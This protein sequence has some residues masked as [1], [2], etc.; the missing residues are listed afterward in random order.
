MSSNETTLLFILGT[1][2]VLVGSFT[3]IIASKK[4]KDILASIFLAVGIAGLLPLLFWFVWTA[5]DAASV[6]GYAF[7]D[8]L[9]AGVGAFVVLAFS[10]PFIAGIP[11]ALS[12]W[13]SYVLFLKCCKNPRA[14]QGVDPND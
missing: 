6:H 8:A 14:E 1:F 4:Q 13:V 7:T 12:A 11:A 3:G 9:L 5:W 2:G 10:V